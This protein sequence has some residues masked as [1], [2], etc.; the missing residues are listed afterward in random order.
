MRKILVPIL[1]LLS[2]VLLGIAFGLASLSIATHTISNTVV[3]VSYYQAVWQGEYMTA[4]NVIGFFLLCFAP[5]FVLVGL[6]PF[7]FR[8]FVLCGAALAAIVAGVFI[9]LTPAQYFG[10]D[11]NKYT[12][13]GGLIATGVLVII[14][15]VLECLAALL[16][17]KKE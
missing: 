5:A 13:N 1:G 17:F 14:A 15:G 16:D 8:K 6:L 11:V 9:L 2:L 7:K 3:G 4:L 10:A 12:I